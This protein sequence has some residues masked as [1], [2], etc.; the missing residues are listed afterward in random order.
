MRVQA[1][2]VLCLSL[3]LAGCTIPAQESVPQDSISTTLPIP[4]FPEEYKLVFRLEAYDGEEQTSCIRFT[5]IRTKEGFYCANSAGESCLFLFQSPGLY[6]LYALQPASGEL[7]SNEGVLLTPAGAEHLQSLLCDLELLV[8][9]TSGLTETSLAKVKGRPCHIL[10]GQ[11]STSG[12]YICRRMYCIDGETGLALQ[13]SIH[14]D[15]N[16]GRTLSYIVTCE[17]F[18]TSGVQL[19][20]HTESE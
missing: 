11:Q 7:V 8:R 4:T 16:G 5:A 14:Y 2:V 12:P 10:Q 19:P 6:H 18:Q 13:Q 20:E 17:V 9:D 15:A 1:F 3:L